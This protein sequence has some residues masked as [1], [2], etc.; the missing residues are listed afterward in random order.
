MTVKK[1]ALAALLAA[2]TRGWAQKCAARDPVCDSRATAAMAW[3]WGRFGD[4]DSAVYL[5]VNAPG[6]YGPATRR[7]LERRE[8]KFEQLE[9]WAR[10]LQDMQDRAAW[11][12]VVEC[13]EDG[14]REAYREWRTHK[15]ND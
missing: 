11:L 6:S 2:S 10:K 7:R 4:S 12:G 9:A 13:Y 1:I 14:A 8:H 3:M 5:V 15:E